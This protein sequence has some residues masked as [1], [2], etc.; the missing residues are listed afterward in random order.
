[1]EAPILNM[2][3]CEKCGACCRNVERWRNNSKKLSE[4]L[5]VELVFPYKDI[6]GICEFLSENNTCTIYEQRPNSCRTEYIFSLLKKKG[7]SDEDL[8]SMQI[9]SCIINRKRTNIIINKKNTI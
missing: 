6:G 3:T 5:G 7:Y 8:L 2:F 4:L 9:Q 1:M